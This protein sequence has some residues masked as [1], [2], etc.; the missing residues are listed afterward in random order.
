MVYAYLRKHFRGCI[1]SLHDSIVVET[2]ERVA[3]SIHKFDPNRSKFTTF[4]IGFARLVALEK[5]RKELNICF[6]EELEEISVPEPTESSQGAK[7]L[8]QEL[9]RGPYAACL[10]SLDE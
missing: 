10:E 2:I 5:L 6:L 7:T 8:L 4:L 9:L 1:P 3:N